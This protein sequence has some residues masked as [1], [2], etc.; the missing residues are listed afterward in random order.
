MNL[1]FTKKM[2]LVL[3]GIIFCGFV[4][5]TVI[6]YTDA[7]RLEEVTL[8]NNVIQNWDKTYGLH[9]D[10]SILSQPLDSLAKVLLSRSSVYKIDI[11]YSMFN[12]IEIKTNNFEPVCFILDRF[13]QKIY[14]IT[15]NSRIINLEN[16]KFSWDNP[17]LTSV[18]FNN[19]YD[20][21]LDKRV[22][23][24]IP[25]LIKLKKENPDLYRLIEEIDFGNRRFLKVAVDG[26]NYRL[27][28]RTEYFKEEMDK[29]VD[30]ISRFDTDLENVNLIDL[31]FKDMIITNKVKI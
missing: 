28:V 4:I 27:K 18:A 11:K 21:C 20:Y 25:R 1:S 23:V 16:C 29:F 2:K 12:K 8:N 3:F 7:C 24:I 19:I 14:G 10:K 22:D 15:K 6:N 30:F 17:V 26:L 5:M 31:R 9:S 13:T